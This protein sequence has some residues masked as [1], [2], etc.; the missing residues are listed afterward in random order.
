MDQH[1]AAGCGRPTCG[2]ETRPAVADPQKL[3]HEKEEALARKVRVC[4]KMFS[5]SQLAHSLRRAI[6][7]P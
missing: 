5:D 4:G 7:T 3:L 1:F 2:S 6:V